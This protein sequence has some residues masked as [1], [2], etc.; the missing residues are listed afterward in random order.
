MVSIL[1]K[2][3]KVLFTNN[4]YWEVSV[5]YLKGE[6]FQF[7]FEVGLTQKRDH[8]GFRFYVEIFRLN[9]EVSIYDNRHWDYVNDC[10][11]KQ[12]GI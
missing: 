1:G 12:N 10:W 5:N 9:F 4:K 8:A 11:E 3:G 7:L 6:P 2:Y